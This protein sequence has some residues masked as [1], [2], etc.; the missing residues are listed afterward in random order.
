MFKQFEYYII[1]LSGD[2]MKLNNK[3]WGVFQMIWMTGI[4]LFFFLLAIILIVNYYHSMNYSL[5]NKSSVAR[6]TREQMLEDLQ[7]AGI[8]YIEYNYK[9]IRNLNASKITSEKLFSVGLF[10]KDLY[11]GCTGYVIASKTN[12]SIT[13]DPYIKCSDYKSPGYD[14]N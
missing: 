14:Q 4:I 1:S 9:N 8:R 7:T 6:R 12:N 5:H 10:A 2:N 11:S 13:V 3:G